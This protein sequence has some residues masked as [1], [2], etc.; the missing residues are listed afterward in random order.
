MQEAI[1]VLLII[2]FITQVALPLVFDLPLFWLFKKKKKVSD[3]NVK[4]SDLTSEIQQAKVVKQKA[5]ETVGAVKQ[6][7]DEILKS[8]EE[9]KKQTD[10]L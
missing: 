3:S 10:E 2:L 6:K 8:A 9:I 4:G 7:A 1:P 5:E